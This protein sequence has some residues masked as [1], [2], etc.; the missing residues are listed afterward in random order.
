M[1]KNLWVGSEKR[2]Y[3][4]TDQESFRKVNKERG[5]QVLLLS[6]KTSCTA[7][8]QDL[9]LTVHSLEAAGC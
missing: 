9:D 3:D 7:P 4:K 5:K 2:H 8:L 6:S 1:K